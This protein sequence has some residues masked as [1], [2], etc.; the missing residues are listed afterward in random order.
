MPADQQTFKAKL[1]SNHHH[2]VKLHC[3][4]KVTEP[5]TG[6]T[7]SLERATPQ[8]INAHTLLLKLKEVGPTGAA[9]DIVTTHPVAFDE[10]PAKVHYTHVTIEAGT[11]SFTI[12][13]H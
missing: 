4:G 10:D 7:V 8:G 11:S 9:G 6:W 3:T 2:K 1:E 12:P 13:V 5:T